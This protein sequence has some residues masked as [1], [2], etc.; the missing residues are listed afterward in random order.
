MAFNPLTGLAVAAATSSLRSRLEPS[1]RLGSVIDF[2]NQ[3]FRLTLPVL[4]RICKELDCKL[5]VPSSDPD[6]SSYTPRFFKDIGYSSYSA[7]D[8]NDKM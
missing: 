6:F 1:A 7:I 5:S 2:G 8:M 3:R 4:K